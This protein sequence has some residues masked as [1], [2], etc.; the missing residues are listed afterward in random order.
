MGYVQ[1]PPTVSTHQTPQTPEQRELEKKRAE[2][3]ELE[4]TLSDRELELVTLQGHL[5]TFEALYFRTLGRFFAELDNVRAQVAEAKARREP[6]NEDLCQ[7]A[8]EARSR[9][10]ESVEAVNSALLKAAD[11]RPSPASDELKR[12]Y[13]EIAKQLHP[14][15]STDERERGRRTRLMAEAN[16]AY[17]AGDEA[18]LRAI[19]DEWVSSPESVHGEGVAAELVRTI[20]KIHQVNRR[21]TDIA[22]EIAALTQSELFA[23]WQQVD[24]ATA[25]NRSLLEEMAGDLKEQIVAAHAELRAVM[26]G[27]ATI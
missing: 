20:R 19:L 25:Q 17:A 23:L 16:R 2:L 6:L 4:G 7:R 13:R 14:D 10:S 18:R 22:T 21:L 12:L 11:V 5:R 24:A 8:S 9:A 27:E 3:S 1:S 26:S 15:L